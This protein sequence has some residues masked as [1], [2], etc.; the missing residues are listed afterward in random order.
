MFAVGGGGGGTDLFVI[1]GGG[2]GKEPLCLPPKPGE[3]G[4]GKGRPA[5]LGGLDVGGG[6]LFEL[7][8]PC[9]V[10]PGGAEGGPLTGG[11]GGCALGTP[12]AAPDIFECKPV[13]GRPEAELE[14]TFSLLLL[15]FAIEFDT[16][17]CISDKSVSL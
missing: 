8:A 3:G 17:L 5:I 14:F 9:D 7:E 6:G 4:G 15:K 2:G 10:P 16:D 13:E 1:G 12:G 11:G